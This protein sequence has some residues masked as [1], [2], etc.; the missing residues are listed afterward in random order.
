MPGG[1][2]IV[3]VRVLITG[4]NGQLGRELTLTA[5][6]TAVVKATTR[7]E[8]DLGDSEAIRAV[9]EQFEPTL[10]L[11]AAAYTAVDQ[12]EAEP[13][14]AWRVN[15]TAPALLA[16]SVHSRRDCRL[17]QVST[18]YV[19]A[20]TNSRPYK[21]DDETAPLGVYGR[22]KLEGERAVLKVLG[23]RALV[24]RT[25]W[26]YGK[27][28]KNFVHTMMRLMAE[29]RSVRVVADQ[30]GCPTSTASLAG[31]L[32]AFAQRESLAGIW[33][34]SDAGAASWYDFAVA[35]A[36]DGAAVGL[37]PMNVEVVPISTEEYPTPARRPP[38]SL[39]DRRATV[40]ALGT[41]TLHWRS[42]LRQVLEQIKH[43]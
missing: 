22:T 16:E 21:P 14:M 11:N 4:A 38:Y 20:G 5:P 37:L 23:P 3:S 29:R 28:G 2:G 31:A 24:L 6:P 15:V 39:L 10:V 1:C 27:H 35:I 43:G 18:N 13:D 17:I 8:L 41:S 25:G 36:E 34:W 9:V 26:V 33:H 32:W 40:A 42:R 30:I 7:S 19:F 12:A